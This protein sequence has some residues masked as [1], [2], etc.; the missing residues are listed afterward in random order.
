MSV[1]PV[2][3]V[4][5]R[6]RPRWLLRILLIVGVPLLLCCGGCIWYSTGIATEVTPAQRAAGAYLDALAAGDEGAARARVC[7]SGEAYHNEMASRWR[8]EGIRRH[9]ITGAKVE[10]RNFDDLTA[11][12]TAR[13]VGTNGTYDMEILLRKRDGDW[14]V[15][16]E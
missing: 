16:G 10:R 12:A 15:C 14:Q 1:Q 3:P 7:D 9:E 11:T 6:R 8:A 2:Q 5:P 13:L 4:P